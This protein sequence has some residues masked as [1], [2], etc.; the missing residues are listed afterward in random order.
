LLDLIYKFPQQQREKYYDRIQLFKQNLTQLKICLKDAQVIGSVSS[1]EK[2]YQQVYMKVMELKG[3]IGHIDMS[4][5]RKR[6]N[7]LND[8][9]SIIA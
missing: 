7:T 6:R 8:M 2:K 1:L 4:Q 3:E 5:N 9:S